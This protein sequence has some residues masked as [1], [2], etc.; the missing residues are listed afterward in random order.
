MHPLQDLLQSECSDSD[1]FGQA[2]EVILG[3]RAIT[4]KQFANDMGYSESVISRVIKMNHLPGWVNYEQI[5]KIT[6]ELDCT[7]EE[8]AKIIIAFICTIMK[9]RGLG[10]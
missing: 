7:D 4:Q 10:I 1:T 8:L 2:L 6:R 3:D 5:L 9:K